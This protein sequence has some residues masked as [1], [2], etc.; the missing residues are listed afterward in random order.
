MD[1]RT[2][3]GVR[4][5]DAIPSGFALPKELTTALA[6]PSAHLVAR[7]NEHWRVVD[8]SLQW[9][10]QRKKG[11]PRKKNSGWADNSFCRTREGLLRCALGCGEVEV[12]ALT[13]IRSLPDYHVDWEQSR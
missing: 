11:N 10:L 4:E 7:L 2:E 13:K 12:S 6:H 1:I 3:N 8:D 9:I 5:P